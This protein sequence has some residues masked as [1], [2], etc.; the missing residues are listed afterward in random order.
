MRG[1]GEGEEEMRGGGEGDETMGRRGRP[2][3]RWLECIKKDI[4]KAE[5]EYDDWMAFA[6]NER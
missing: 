4:K 2:H 1:G 3:L 6:P 5:V